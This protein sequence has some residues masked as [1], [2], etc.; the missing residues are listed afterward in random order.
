MKRPRRKTAAEEENERLAYE[1]ICA[2]C[3]ETFAKEWRQ[4]PEHGGEP[5][6]ADCC[7][8]CEYYEPDCRSIYTCRF[9]IE[10]REA[11]DRKMIR[12]LREMLGGEGN[13]EE[14]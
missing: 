3:G 8:A 2:K 14:N 1:G 9:W 5:V 6:C 7:K 11:R 4:C 10:N 12:Q 13:E